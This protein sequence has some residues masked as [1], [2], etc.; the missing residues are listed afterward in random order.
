MI[1][2]HALS[3]STV[4]YY[5][6]LLYFAP[7]TYQHHAT[8]LMLSSILMCMRAIRCGHVKP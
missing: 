3:C 4:L 7:C 6:L 2:L 8:L 5:T 1:C